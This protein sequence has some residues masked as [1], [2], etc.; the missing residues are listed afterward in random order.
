ML[1]WFKDNA[2]TKKGQSLGFLEL[3][4][5][6]EVKEIGTLKKK[7]GVVELVLQNGKSRFVA[8]SSSTDVYQA[9]LSAFKTL[10]A[11]YQE[12]PARSSSPRSPPPLKSPANPPPPSTAPIPP[13]TTSQ[14][15][16]AKTVNIGGKF[17]DDKKDEKNSQPPVQSSEP[18]KT[19]NIGG[20]FSDDDDDDDEEDEEALMK[21]MEKEKEKER[22][23]RQKEKEK[24]KEEQ[25]EREKKEA[26]ERLKNAAATGK[27]SLGAKKNWKRA[28]EK[29]EDYLIHMQEV[30]RIE[31]DISLDIE[32]AAIAR[33]VDT[34]G[35]YVDKVGDVVNWWL[36]PLC[37]KFDQYFKG[38][39]KSQALA[40]KAVR[41]QWSTGVFKIEPGPKQETGKDHSLGD[42]ILRIWTLNSPQKVADNF[43]SCLKVAFDC[44]VFLLV[45]DVLQR[46]RKAVSASLAQKI[47]F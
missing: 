36:D 42:L 29:R 43:L 3:S 14:Q 15:M 17:S 45:F 16:P 38:K 32:K 13:T 2:S 34:N 27:L 30:T 37:K 35:K 4:T 12:R 8:I 19:V 44:F 39:G 46:T 47:I 6:K 5:V 1:F 20:D 7:N 23:R 9:W 28:R 41:Q 25:R 40:R 24:E 11:G 10:S 33:I 31:N 21:K 18:V 22:E 26:E